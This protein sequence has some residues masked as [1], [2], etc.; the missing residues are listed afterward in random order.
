VQVRN[1]YFEDVPLG[2]LAGVVTPEGLV[3]SRQVRAALTRWRIHPWLSRTP[4][5]KS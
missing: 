5:P 1:P 3:S 2:L 4:G